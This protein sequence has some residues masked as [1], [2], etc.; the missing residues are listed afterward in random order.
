MYQSHQKQ[1]FLQGITWKPN[2]FLTYTN[3]YRNY[4]TGFFSLYA[5]A[6]SEASTLQN[7]RGFYQGMN[8][9]FHPK[10]ELQAYTDFYEF[11]F[12]RYQVNFPTKGYDYV[13]QLRYNISSTSYLSARY[14][15]EKKEESQLLMDEKIASKIIETNEQVR[16][17]WQ[18][19]S[20][21]WKFQT[22][23]NYH[24]YKRNLA[25]KGYLLSQT[26]HSPRYKAP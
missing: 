14:K 22:N 24:F 3:I 9:F 10:W 2:S 7:E 11:P 1:A 23:L 26:I 6:F 8:I 5:N 21:F 4:Q 19:E 15:I 16:L 20:G 25:E 18:V 17:V 13:A 12:F